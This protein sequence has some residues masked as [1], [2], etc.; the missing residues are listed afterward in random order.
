ML[1]LDVQLAGVERVQTRLNRILG[2]TKDLSPV[3][4]DISGTLV[5]EF[6]AN[7]AAQGGVLQKPWAPRK[8]AYAWPILNKTGHLKNTWDKE[9]SPHELVIRN[10]VAYAPYHHFGTPRLPVRRLVGKTPNILKMVVDR[11]NK[12]L[13]SLSR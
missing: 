5:S 10:P 6:K 9:I 13:T 2:G 11:I 7:F 8:K 12:Y 3:L 4:R 1:K